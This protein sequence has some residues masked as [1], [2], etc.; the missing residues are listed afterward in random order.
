MDKRGIYFI[1]IWVQPIFWMVLFN[2]K[3]NRLDT[4]FKPF[5]ICL[6]IAVVAIELISSLSIAVYNIFA[7]TK[8]MFLYSILGC[9]FTWYLMEYKG[10]HFPQALSISALAVHIGSYYWEAPYIIRN[11]ILVGFEWDW[12]LHAMVIFLALYIRDTVGWCPDKKKLI[13]LLGIGLIIS[14]IVMIL[15]PI[16]PGVGTAVRWNAPLYLL[17]RVVCSTIIFILIN[18][19]KIKETVA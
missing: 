6:F 7:S 13:S 18:K 4:L 15:A 12:V 9:V 11:A 5:A 17:N 1:I 8:L 19:D 3:T 14:M 16:S 10:W 2:F